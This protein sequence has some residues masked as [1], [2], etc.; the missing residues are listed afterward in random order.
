MK[1]TSLGGKILSK[2]LFKNENL[3]KM[4]KNS[5]GKKTAVVF[6]YVCYFSLSKGQSSN[7]TEIKQMHIKDINQVLAWKS[8]LTTKL[9]SK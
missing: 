9:S 5:L 8:K 7:K 1:P 2:L 4:C 3:D 6:K